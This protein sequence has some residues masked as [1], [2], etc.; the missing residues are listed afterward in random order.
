M[1]HTLGVMGILIG[2]FIVVAGCA[3]LCVDTDGGRNYFERGTVTSAEGSKADRCMD[4]DRLVEYSCDYDGTFQSDTVSCSQMAG[5]GGVCYDGACVRSSVPT[6][7]AFPDGFRCIGVAACPASGKVRTS[8]V[9]EMGK[10][11]VVQ[12]AVIQETEACEVTEKELPAGPVENGEPFSVVIGCEHLTAGS[13]LDMTLGITYSFSDSE[14]QHQINGK[15]AVVPEGS[16]W[17]CEACV[18]EERVCGGIE[19]V[20]CCSGLSCKLERNY[21]G[22]EGVCVQDEGMSEKVT[23]VFDNAAQEETCSS[24]KGNCTGVDSC[25][26][27]VTGIE[28]EEVVWK[29]SCGGY[30]YTVIDGTPEYAKFSCGNDE[31]CRT[32]DDCLGDAFCNKPSCTAEEGLC[33][34]PGGNYCTDIARPVCGCDDITYS[35]DCYRK[36]ARVSKAYEGRCDGAEPACIDS[37]AGVSLYIPGTTSWCP[38]Q[39]MGM[40]CQAFIDNCQG[41]VLS[42]GYCY[43]RSMYVE[44]YT[45]PFGCENG[46]CVSLPTKNADLVVTDMRFSPPSPTTES[47]VTVTVYV[48]NTGS[49]SAPYFVVGLYEQVGEQ[50]AVIHGTSDAVSGST[51]QG[52]SDI[53]KKNYLGPG[54]VMK[55][56]FV[57]GNLEEGMHTFMAKADIYNQVDEESETN[58]ERS[59]SVYVSPTGTSDFDLQVTTDSDSYRVGNVARITVTVTG[60]DYTPVADTRVEVSIKEGAA[61]WRVMGLEGPLCAEST[62]AYP[63]SAQGLEMIQE[64]EQTTICT[65]EGKYVVNNPGVPSIEVITMGESPVDEVSTESVT[66]ITLPEPSVQ[67]T[68]SAVVSGSGGAS[69]SVMP[70]KKYTHTVRAEA[71]LKGTTKTD[72]AYFAVYQENGHKYVRLGEKFELR[73]NQIAYVTDN[74]YML[75]KDLT[76][77]CMTACSAT[78]GGSS[79][80]CTTTCYSSV[81]VEYNGRSETVYLNEGETVTVFNDVEIRTLDVGEDSVVLVVNKQKPPIDTYNNV[82]IIMDD[83]YEQGGQIK[84]SVQNT[85]TQTVWYYGACQDPYTIA[86]YLN[87]DYHLITVSDP[88]IPHCEALIKQTLLP[89]E[90]K[91]I[92]VWDQQAFRGQ[93]KD[94]QGIGYQ[95]EPGMYRVVFEY[96]SEENNQ[97]IT[98][99]DFNIGQGNVQPPPLPSCQGCSRDSTCLPYGTRLVDGEA[100]VFCSVDG[101]FSKQR[102]EDASCQNNYECLSNFCGNG[103]CV[104][105]EGKL[106]NTENLL[107]KVIDWLGKIFGG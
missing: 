1:K 92:A 25:V 76:F 45:C 50:G 8:L 17:A 55:K 98:S 104:D 10:S 22:A 71:Y 74:N 24:G 72:Y 70:T 81:T 19:G 39:G 3:P 106:Q 90:V 53:G 85:G 79:S 62:C 59:V 5:A 46:A 66:S 37:D 13:M 28:G 77:R 4:S 69:S 12:D 88:C 48:K 80:S 61:S 42:E 47:K 63:V 97:H 7:C 52:S 40:P 44:K 67:S 73:K 41:S 102:A 89:G 94:G 2:L 36:I 23:C 14:I 9:N 15:V 6:G 99:Y 64:C 54:E 75:V 65:W 32:D 58:N 16:D 68:T 100:P 107:Q 35:N 96:F 34:K 38:P 43:N 31:P 56:S 60:R 33:A 91:K 20:I 82:N 21:P 57:V 18:S 83:F 26:V 103:R 29:S 11:I 30:A 49:V 84:I 93:C 86:Q 78:E 27:E 51:D 101:S 95:V 87:G 105:I